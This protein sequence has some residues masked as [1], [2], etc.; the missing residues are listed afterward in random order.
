MITPPRWT[1]RLLTSLGAEPRYREAILGDLAEEFTIRV[2]EQDVRTARRWYRREA[3][4]AVPH[5]LAS[6]MRAL[7]LRDV[8]RLALA[9]IVAGVVH[10]L[11]GTL[12]P[13]VTVM[14][15][16]VR[17]DSLGTVAAAWRDVLNDTMAIKW[18][19][20]S[21]LRMLPVLAGFIAASLNPRA[22]IPAA[23]VLGALDVGTTV[24]ALAFIPQLP[25]VVRL[26]PL[27]AVAPIVIGGAIRALM[28]H[29]ERAADQH[30]DLT[31]A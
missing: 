5:L 14:S 20:L 4:R 30:A 29:S 2:E 7:T 31:R 17:P 15:L 22:R 28:D 25:L 13:L 21:L 10:R 3:W 24:Y 12:I 6:W 26:M 9:V 16:G 8:V 1:E 11:L 23:L 19:A 27:T 18:A